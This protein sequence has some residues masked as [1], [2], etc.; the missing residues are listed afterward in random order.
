MLI[1]MLF[2]LIKFILTFTSSDKLKIEMTSIIR[3]KISFALSLV[4]LITV[5]FSTCIFANSNE[6]GAYDYPVRPGSD[7]WK[8]LD[9]HVEMIEACQIPTDILNN[10]STDA[11]IDTILDYPLAIDMYAFNSIESGYNSVYA[12][13]NG[14]SEL[15]IREDAVSKLLDKYNNTP[16]I[17]ARNNS[18][19]LKPIFNL[20]LLES[21][22]TDEKYYNELTSNEK[23]IFEN[24]VSE[25][26][27]QRAQNKGAYAM[28]LSPFYEVLVAE[29][30]G[31]IMPRDITTYVNTP[32]GTKVEVIIYEAEFD[33]AYIRELNATYDSAYPQATRISSASRKYNCHT[34]AWYSTSNQ[35]YWM[36][37]PSAYMDDGSYNQTYSSS[38]GNKAHYVNGDHSANYTHAGYVFTSKWGGAGVYR[39]KLDYCPYPAD[40]INYFT[41]S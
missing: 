21:I 9:T 34:Y 23:G 6:S 22:L 19:D 11:L 31:G 1:K 37:D 13:F 33:S 25:K 39:H 15:E 26:Y 24:S 20:T 32:K 30:N 2:I 5:L 12:N 36:G 38:I 17:S 27:S 14:F 35:T 18:S 16:V 4:L 28:S 8:S 10:M 3:R 29:Q 41:R 40:N 7:E